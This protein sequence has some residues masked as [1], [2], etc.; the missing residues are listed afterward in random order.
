MRARKSQHFTGRTVEDRYYIKVVAGT[1]F[2]SSYRPEILRKQGILA[3]RILR[4][5]RKE[6]LASKGYKAKVHR[7]GLKK[8]PNKQGIS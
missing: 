8:H 1:R 6:A 4:Y 2:E 7:L 3:T 5:S